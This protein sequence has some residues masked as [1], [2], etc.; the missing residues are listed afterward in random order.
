MVWGP[1]RLTTTHLPLAQNIL[2]APVAHP[3]PCTVGTV[4]PFPRLNWQGRET[5]HSLQSNADI[6]NGWRNI[7]TPHILLLCVERGN[8]LFCFCLCNT[9][10]SNK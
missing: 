4:S 8:V 9:I 7:S 6:V 10:H 5:A 3:A 2:T 1:I